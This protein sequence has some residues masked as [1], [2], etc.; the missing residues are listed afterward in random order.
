MLINNS[1]DNVWNIRHV[2][3]VTGGNQKY[4]FSIKKDSRV[5]RHEVGFS[6]P[7]RKW[8]IL[9]IN[10][11]IEVNPYKEEDY[12]TSIVLEADYMQKKM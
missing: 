10:Q 11:E 9:S 1:N 6:L 7:Q 5:Q 12:I 4:I 8:A 3:V 2:E